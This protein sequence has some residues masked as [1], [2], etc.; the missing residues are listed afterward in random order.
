M[1]PEIGVILDAGTGIFRAR[2]LIETSH[3]DIFL[4]HVHLDHSIGITFLFDVLHEKNV[5]RVTVHLAAD[6]VDAVNKHL[7]HP[8]LFP[9]QPDFE[10]RPFSGNRI[11]L[12]DGSSLSTL[13]LKHP[14]GSHGFRIDWEDR[15]LAYITDTVAAK[16]APYVEGIRGVETLVHECYFPDGWED[17]AELTGHS[18]LTPV[19][20]V[21]REAGVNKL[22]L[23]HTNPQDED[24]KMLDLN[25]I[26]NI[27]ENI[28]VPDD[29]DV[30]EV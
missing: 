15:G 22:L 30:I 6:K 10:L 11:E 24:L 2:D 17:R 5:G 27:F 29:Q 16:N 25:S 18:C 23:V 1:L 12:A 8:T 21:A 20:E 26:K 13:P 3:L 14:G 9:A 19:A 4:S 28:R 7:F